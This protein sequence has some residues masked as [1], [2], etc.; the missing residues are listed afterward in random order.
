MSSHY[1]GDS[2]FAES[3]SNSIQITVNPEG[4]TTD[5]KVRGYYDPSTGKS[6]STPYYGFIYLVDAQPYGNSASLSSPNGI[7]TGSVS[8][9][10]G[11]MP[12]GTAPLAS[13]GIAELQTSIIPGGNN[14]LKASFQGDASFQTSTSNAVSFTVQPAISSLGMTTEKEGYNPGEPVTITATFSSGSSN[15]SLDSLGLAP[16]GTVSFIADGTTQ[17]GTATVTGIAGTA[18]S[19]ATASAT[20]TATGISSGN[21]NFTATYSGDS[22]YAPSSSANPVF[23]QVISAATTISLAPASSTIKQNQTLQL[24]ANLSTSG[25]LPAP[26]GTMTFIVIRNT[27]YIS[28]WTSTAQISNGVATVTIPASALPLGSFTLAANYSGDKYYGSGT[29]ATG[30]LQVT[31][32]GTVTP[33]LSLSLPSA[34]IYEA[35][36]IALTVSGPSGDPVPTGPVI[37]SS[38]NNTWMLVNGSASFTAFYPW[39]PGSNTITVTYLGDSTYASASATGTFTEMGLSNITFSPLYPTVYVGDPLTFSVSIA[40]LPNLP[41]PTGNIT[42]A[43]GSYSSAVTAL[44]SGTVSITIPANTL[45]VGSDTYGITYSGD[46]YYTAGTVSGLINVTSTPPS[47]ALGG[48]NLNLSAG[49]TVNNTSTVSI[50]PAGGFTGQVTLTAKVT[51]A[52]ANAVNQPTLSFGNTSPV[53][54]TSAGVAT[55][56]LTVTTIAFTRAMLI[57]EDHFKT[58]WSG[59]TVPALGCCVFLALSGWRR[60][61]QRWLDVFALCLVILAGIS[62][63]GGGGSTGGSASGGS[64]GTSGTT[65]GVYTITITG[66]S[67]QLTATTTITVTVK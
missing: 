11:S 18:S 27:D 42:V 7:A 40:Q 28:V 5:L 34:P 16:T 17:L 22:N 47:I 29:S 12:L 13:D 57:R 33:T 30:S 20:Y 44:S 23:I 2:A 55:A 35:L 3:D 9:N 63:C 26:T 19:F 64:G 15:K 43:S 66:A 54:I 10:S 14:S 65:P 4:S 39:Q 51:S 32:S 1:G 21:H 60:K 25:S 62:A 41:P 49:A 53:T 50:T 67:S 46:A 56:A 36:P 24:T 61:S 59:I 6:S 8:F 31:S 52:P 37:I 45:P 38:S 58:G 48:T